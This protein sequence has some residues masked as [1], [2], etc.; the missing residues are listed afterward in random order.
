MKVYQIELNN[1]N[2]WV[3]AP[4][5]WSALSFVHSCTPLDDT[6]ESIEDLI[7]EMIPESKWDEEWIGDEDH[8]GKLHS[9]RKALEGNIWHE[10]FIIADEL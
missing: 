10:A 1:H 3:A 7:V 5:M 6:D 9:I 2:Q 8:P 4:N